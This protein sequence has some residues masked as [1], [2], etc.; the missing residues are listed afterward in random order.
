[1][2]SPST[3]NSAAQGQTHGA[4]VIREGSTL[5]AGPEASRVALES[6]YRPASRWNS[7]LLKCALI[8][9][10]GPD[11]GL[12]RA[13]AGIHKMHIGWVAPRRID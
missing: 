4:R 1:M 11:E 8:R 7:R 13:G 9:W 3:R 10:N 12:G 6:D 2:V 5:S